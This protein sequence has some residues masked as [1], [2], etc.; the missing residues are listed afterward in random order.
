MVRNANVASL[1]MLVIKER[2]QRFSDL[3]CFSPRHVGDAVVVFDESRVVPLF[4]ARRAIG[5]FGH[6]C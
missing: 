3:R 4:Q 5:F 6:V 1:Y 2:T